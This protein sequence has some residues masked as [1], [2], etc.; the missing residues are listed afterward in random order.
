M[1]EARVVAENLHDVMF[2]ALA[3]SRAT[4]NTINDR[5]S[6]DYIGSIIADRRP[7]DNIFGYL[8]RFDEIL[9]QQ[10]ARFKGQKSKKSRPRTSLSLAMSPRI[11]HYGVKGRAKN[12]SFQPAFMPH[13]TPGNT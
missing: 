6:A 5:Q 2:A 10:V 13:T 4:S 9:S 8:T 7:G 3:E 11:R 12:H 1:R